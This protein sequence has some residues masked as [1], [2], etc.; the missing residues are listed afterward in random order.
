MEILVFSVQIV[1]PISI[2]F[3]KLKHAWSKCLNENPIERMAV[4]GSKR[5][6]QYLQLTRIEN[7]MGKTTLRATEKA[8][9]VK[10][11]SVY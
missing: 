11:T 9:E 5:H 2:L 10:K 3:Q 8:Q 7:T 6:S 4:E 1:F